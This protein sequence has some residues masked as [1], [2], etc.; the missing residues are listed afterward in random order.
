L[1]KLTAAG[2]GEDAKSAADE[3]VIKVSGRVDPGIIKPGAL[4]TTDEVYET[5]KA[6]VLGALRKERSESGFKVADAKLTTQQSEL[7][8]PAAGDRRIPFTFE[9]R[10]AT[11]G[12]AVENTR[13]LESPGPEGPGKSIIPRAP[14]PPPPA[15]PPA[16]PGGAKEPA[17]PAPAVE[18]ADADG[19]KAP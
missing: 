9:V 5:L 17:P 3:V 8:R 7:E 14:G 6:Y 12:V 19:G 15:E 2:P 10:L 1:E 18:G 16:E 11:L 13:D 4:A